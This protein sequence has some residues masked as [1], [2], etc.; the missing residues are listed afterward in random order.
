MSGCY[1]CIRLSL[2]LLPCRLFRPEEVMLTVVNLGL[3]KVEDMDDV[4]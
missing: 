4:S 1:M 3:I 2:L